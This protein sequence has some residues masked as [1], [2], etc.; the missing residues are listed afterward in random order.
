M[1]QDI[2][3]GAFDLHQDTITAAWLWPGASTPED[4]TIPHEGKALH[5]LVRELLARG[6]AQACYEAGPW[7]Y[8]PQRQLA[9]WGLPCDVIAPSLIPRRPGDR[10]KTDRR[11]AQKLVGLSRADALTP[12]RVPTPAEENA[13]ELVRGREVAGEDALRALHRLRPFRLRPGLRTAGRPGT[14]AWWRGAPGLRLPDPPAQRAR[15][16]YLLTAQTARARWKALD[17]AVAALASGEPWVTPVAWL[18]CFR[19]IDTLTAVTLPREVFAGR[20]FGGPRAC[21]RFVGL[22]PRE[23]SSGGGGWRGRL[24]QAGNAPLR[25]VLGEAAGP[26]QHRADRRAAPRRRQAGQPPA[27]VAIAEQAER[28]LSRRFTHLV[29]RG[30]RRTVAAT[31]VAR[32]LCGFLWAALVTA[33]R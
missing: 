31:A 23:H 21:M 33:P 28:R 9:G 29:L 18:R 2:T 6:P 7:G 1:R 13:R 24:T 10:I 22:V 15:D 25:R 16:E 5:R 19:G 3:P 12:I 27:V 26:D 20:R 4:R 11:D 14:E 30:T 8:E 32:E 17:P